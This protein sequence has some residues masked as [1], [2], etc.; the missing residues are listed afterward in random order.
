MWNE[1]EAAYK[2]AIWCYPASAEAFM[3]LAQLYTKM[4]KFDEALKLAEEYKRIDPLNFRVDAMIEVIRRQRD[5]DKM[6]T[7]LQKRVATGTNVTWN[8]YINLARVYEQ[9]GNRAGADMLYMQM[10]SPT[11]TVTNEAA[12]K[13]LAKVY[14]NRKDLKSLERVLKR[15]TE[16]QPANWRAWVDLAAARLGN[17]N[18]EGAFEAMTKAVE[19]DPSQVKRRLWQDPRFKMLSNSKDQK[20]RDRFNALAQ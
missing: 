10:L 13:H 12:F 18:M 16:V 14:T 3:R 6:I 1:A 15:M 8:D 4:G 7:D 11:S 9:R 2:Q 17:G 5:S 19:I 20:V